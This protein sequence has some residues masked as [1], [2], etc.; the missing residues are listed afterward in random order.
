MKCPTVGRSLRLG[1]LLSSYHFR[2]PRPSPTVRAFL[3]FTVF[4]FWLSRDLTITDIT[5]NSANIMRNNS[6][7]ILFQEG[8]F[9]GTNDAFTVFKAFI[10]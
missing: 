10:V 6:S 5:S 8:A 7:D 9:W 1:K 3:L 2:R 4:T